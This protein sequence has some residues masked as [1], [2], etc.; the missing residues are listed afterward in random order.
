MIICQ[1]A[2]MLWRIEIEVCLYRSIAVGH[3]LFHEIWTVL[4]RLNE[5]YPSNHEVLDYGKKE[6]DEEP[7]RV[8]IRLLLY[9]NKHF[10][11]LNASSCPEPL[12]F[13]VIC[14]DSSTLRAFLLPIFTSQIRCKMGKMTDKRDPIVFGG[15]LYTIFFNN[16]D[17]E[18]ECR[19]YGTDATAKPLSSFN[20][21]TDRF[22]M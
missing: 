21:T 14:T 6:E 11:Y 10:S 18:F 13:W 22:R 19:R 4:K 5:G 20:I 12:W 2:K 16:L 7:F 3:G 9:Q 1:Y 15:A 8:Q 17:L